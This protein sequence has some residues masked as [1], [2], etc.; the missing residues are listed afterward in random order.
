VW[1]LPWLSGGQ[2]EGRG[3]AGDS[4]Q[5]RGPGG[6]THGLGTADAVDARQN[7]AV[8]HDTASTLPLLSPNAFVAP[9]VNP[10]NTVQPSRSLASFRGFGWNGPA[11]R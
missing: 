8:W 5:R 7:V 2:A 1:M 11:T 10:L 3:R 9:Q 6:S 4:G